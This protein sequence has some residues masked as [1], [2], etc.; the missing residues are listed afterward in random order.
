MRGGERREERRNREERAGNTLKVVKEHAPTLY[1]P[2]HLR[3]RVHY[4]P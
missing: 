4:N 1:L 3:T 2:I